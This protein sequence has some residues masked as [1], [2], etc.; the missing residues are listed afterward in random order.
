MAESRGRAGLPGLSA[1]SRPWGE[2]SESCW[3]F[4]TPGVEEEGKQPLQIPQ[5][6]HVS[7]GVV[8]S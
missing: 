5:G 6:I 3:V 2:P 8:G 4:L 7:S 1:G